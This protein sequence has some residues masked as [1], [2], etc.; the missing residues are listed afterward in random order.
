MLCRQLEQRALTGRRSRAM[1][2][3]WCRAATVKYRQ[4][5]AFLPPG[6]DGKPL[7]ALT[8]NRDASL[9]AAA[10]NGGGIGVFSMQRLRDMLA[11]AAGHRWVPEAARD[12][13]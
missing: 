3:H 7:S 13:L 5:A 2:A 6:H 9:L 4:A 11:D 10:A 8:L 1:T 12:A